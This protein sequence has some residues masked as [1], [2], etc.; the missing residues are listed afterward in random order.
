MDINNFGQF[1]AEVWGNVSD[2]AMIAVTLLTAVFLWFTLR[3]Q[4]KVQD[5]QAKLTA[6]EQFK[7]RRLL[8][9]RFTLE[10][11]T[12]QSEIGEEIRIIV[13]FKF[14]ANDNAAFGINLSFDHDKHWELTWDPSQTLDFDKGKGRSFYGTF[15]PTKTEFG[16]YMGF[17]TFNLKF[18]DEYNTQYNQ[19]I[20]YHYVD[21]QHNS[22][23]KFP[24]VISNN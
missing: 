24:K 2:W 18:A 15:L 1:N 6:I 11:E 7:H 20:V 10:G 5:L 14:V 22:S 13:K 8:F 19:S 16:F 17:I 12:N 9:P 21:G 3:S 4:T 23:Y